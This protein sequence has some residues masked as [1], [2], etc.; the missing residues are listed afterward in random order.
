MANEPQQ[1]PELTQDLQR[2]FHLGA[3]KYFGAGAIIA[4]VT[5]GSGETVFAS[6]GGA[7]YG[8]AMLWC[9]VLGALCKGALI[10]SGSRFITLTG[11]SP[12]QSWARLPGLKGWFVPI[13]ALLTCL[14]MPLW[15]AGLPGMLGDFSNWVVG[16]P[17]PATVPGFSDLPLVEQQARIDQYQIYGRYWGTFYVLVALAITWL[18]SYGFLETVQTL[19][20]ALLLFCMVIAAIASKID[21]PAL[22]SGLVPSFPEYEPWVHEKYENLTKRPAWIEVMVY[23]GVIGGGT[24]DYF[25]YIGMLREKTWG[26]LGRSDLPEPTAPPKIATDDPNIDRGRRWLLPAQIDVGIA[27]LAILVFTCCFVILGANVL[28]TNEI[29]PDGFRLLTEQARFLNVLAGG[30]GNADGPRTM[31]QWTVGWV[32]NT[33]IFFAFFGT[34]LGACEIFV[35]SVRE[36][37]VAIFPSWVE[38][39][40]KKFRAWVL[41]GAGGGG[42]ILMWVFSKLD[43]R[44]FVEPASLIGSGLICGLW[45]FAMLYSEWYHLPK[46]L[47]MAWPT[48]LVL[49]VSGVVLT[50]G[51][52][53]GL[54]EYHSYV[55]SKMGW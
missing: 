42:I 10:Y 37:L 27:T 48:R 49:L 51:P 47:R 44:L 30:E 23:L 18:Q 19:I 39:P 9:F 21:W 1:Y 29:V 52:I 2:G 53:Y 41:L 7:I 12:L 36:C 24:Q 45:C 32:Y 4:C 38:I 15:L 3:I 5:I 26:M 16:I 43:A 25:G 54:T 40:L 33:G 55:T 34:I 28:H 50:F 20:V 13:V 35:R 8:Y 17:Q 6:R 22:F 31:L 46:P 14:C 11:C